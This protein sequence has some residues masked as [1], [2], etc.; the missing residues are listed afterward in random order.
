MHVIQ[1]WLFFLSKIILLWREDILWPLSLLVCR[2]EV[3]STGRLS[4]SLQQ[5]VRPVWRGN[6]LLTSTRRTIVWAR[7]VFIL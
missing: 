7:G 1:Y 2:V 4:E 5:I 6:T 3:F